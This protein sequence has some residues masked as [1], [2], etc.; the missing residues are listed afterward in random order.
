MEVVR[1][2]SKDEMFRTL[3]YLSTMGVARFSQ[4]NDQSF[5]LCNVYLT[6]AKQRTC[7]SQ[8]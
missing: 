5:S 3:S 2:N 7:H 4:F 6:I 8:A 1:L